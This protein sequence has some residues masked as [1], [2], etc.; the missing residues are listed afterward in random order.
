[1]PSDPMTMNKSIRVSIKDAEKLRIELAESGRLDPHRK[2]K[3]IDTEQRLLEIP[4]TEDI[5]GFETFLQEDAE[6]YNKW[7]SLEDILRKGISAEELNKL[8]SGWHIIGEIIVITIDPAIDHLKQMIAEALLRMYPS[9][10]TVVRDLG[11][12]GQFRLPKRELLI[13]NNTET[14]NKE[15]GCLFKLDVTKVMF[16]KGNLHEKKLMSKIGTHET[17]VDMFA[18]IGYFTIPMAVHAK[19]EKIVAIE[20]NPESYGYLKENIFLNK[21]ENIVEARNGDCAE[22]TPKGIADRVLMGY[23]NTTHHYLD[24][25]IAAL[26]PEGGIIH[27]HETTPESMVFSRP[28]E[29]IQDAALKAEKK[30]E[31][32]DCRKIKKYS[33]GVWHVVVDARIS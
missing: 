23:V 31:I 19:P 3:L 21:V 18:G 32:L 30:V 22:V 5:E 12:S 13:G 6:F 8:P 16:S 25:G 20:I 28:I 17:I 4:V 29:R 7:Q 27:Y 1:M 33:P 24:S 2:I 11:I 15:H 26:K 9:C 14:I 10:N